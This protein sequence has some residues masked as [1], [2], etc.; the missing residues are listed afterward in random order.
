MLLILKFILSFFIK[1]VFYIL[2][3][4]IFIEIASLTYIKIFLTNKHYNIYVKTI[5]VI[6]IKI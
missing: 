4:I 5:H 2:T 6:F 1:H 3:I